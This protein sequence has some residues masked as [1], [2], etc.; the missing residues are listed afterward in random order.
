MCE[1]RQSI[2]V[3]RERLRRGDIGV[4]ELR[5]LG[6]DPRLGVRALAKAERRRL[7]ARELEQGRLTGMLEHESTLWD[8]GLVRIAGV[9]EVGAGPLAG[10]VVAAAVILSPGA[11]FEEI[12]DSKK[13]SAEQRERLSAEIREQAVAFAVGECSPLEIDCLNILQAAREAMRRAV[14]G[15]PKAPQHL[16]VD[17]RSIPDVEAPQTSLIRGDSRSQ[18]IAAASII[19][20]V[21]R[22]RL[23][24]RLAHTYPEYGFDRHR[25]YGTPEH[26]A[27]LQRHGPC[28]IHRYSFS[29]V[30]KAARESGP[31]QVVR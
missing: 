7:Q 5:R 1:A 18:S 8:R 29:P 23:M 24:A 17:A 6:R 26:L 16:L 25:G 3:L 20:K 12:D 27:A 22:D 28:P 9:D 10:P 4:K 21:E 31:P 13:L 11:S 30:A 15:L 14:A 2:A 19:A